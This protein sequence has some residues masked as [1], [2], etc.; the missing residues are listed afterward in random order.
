M[1]GMD[2]TER[3]KLLRVGSNVKR[4][5]TESLIHSETVGHHSCNV[6]LL[7]Y[8]LTDH[9]CTKG[10]LLHALTHDQA[11][12]Y[13]GDIPAPAKR[14]SLEFAEY[15]RQMENFLTPEGLLPPYSLSSPEEYAIFKAADYLDLCYKCLDEL[16]MG[17]RKILPV[18]N[19]GICYLDGLTLPMA[20]QSVLDEL[21][22]DIKEIE[23]GQ[24]HSG[25][26]QREGQE[27]PEVL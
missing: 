17:N 4:Y 24:I 8:I 9:Q 2:R 5:H 22:A 26:H 7:C 6:A 16:E 20:A 12:K 10:L 3:A 15:I 27:S 14:A 1:S 11:E 23:N 18:L 13:I 21:L 25:L 19:N